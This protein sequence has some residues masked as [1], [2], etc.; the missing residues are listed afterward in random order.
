MLGCGL[1]GL[2]VVG[3]GSVYVRGNSKLRKADIGLL[4]P[5]L[6]D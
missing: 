6:L 1:C 2:E 3:A 5:S 4:P